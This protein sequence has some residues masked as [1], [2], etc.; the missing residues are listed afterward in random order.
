MYSSGVIT[1]EKRPH[2]SVEADGTAF[3]ILVEK[4]HLIYFDSICHINFKH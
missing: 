3:C 4:Y 1:I 2:R